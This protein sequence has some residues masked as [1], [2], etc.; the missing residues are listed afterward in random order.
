MTSTPPHLRAF[1]APTGMPF[2]SAEFLIGATPT[3]GAAVDLATHGYI[4]TEF[5]AAGEASTWA[6]SEVPGVPTEVGHPHAY[7]TRLLVRRPLDPSRAS[8][9]VHLEVLHPMQE[10]A[11]T[12]AAAGEHIVRSGDAWVGVTV[13]AH[14]ATFLRE[15]VDPIR[16]AELDIP[17]EGLEWDIL[18]GV[19]SALRDGGV[20]VLRPERILLSGWSATGSF[21]RVF[22]REGFAGR[23]PNSVDGAVIFISSGGAGDAGYP[24]L[25]A[26]SAPLPPL[27][28][29]RM[30]RDVGVPVFEVLSECESETHFHQLREDSDHIGDAYRLYQVAGTGHIEAWS[31]GRLS[32]NAQLAAIGQEMPETPILEEESDGRLDLVARAVLQRMDDWVAQRRVPP[33]ADRLTFAEDP[34]GVDPDSPPAKGRDLSRDADGNVTGGVRTPWI[35]APLG[36]YFPHGTPAPR[37]P[38]PGAGKLPDWT[39]FGDPAIGAW[40]RATVERFPVTQVLERFPLES[41]YRTAFTAATRQLTEAGLLL[42][43]DAEELLESVNPRWVAATRA[44]DR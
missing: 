1:D 12:W 18:G 41:D 25:S 16:Y 13:Y 42:T 22:L 23:H 10:E 3:L 20:P 9:T 8:G 17:A 35:V 21:V 14:M 27:D 38:A 11:L 15:V 6:V 26:A 30:V 24:P 19:A 29:R 5:L 37:T 28:P 36:R 2:G 34:E 39:P 33:R 40:L 44:T 4:E 7:V 32:N 43:T 31:H